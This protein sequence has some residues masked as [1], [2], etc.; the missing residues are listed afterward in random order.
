MAIRLPNPMLIPIR[1]QKQ[2]Y[3]GYERRTMAE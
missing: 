3:Y 2:A 1:S